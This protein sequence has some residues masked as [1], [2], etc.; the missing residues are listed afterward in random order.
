M[1]D[2]EKLKSLLRHIEN[3]RN[4]AEILGERLIEN[5]EDRLGIELIRNSQIHDLSKFSGIE[6][7]F[8]FHP[9]DKVNLAI[10]VKQHNLT[11]KHH[12]ESWG[13][14]KNMP[15]VY[16]AELACD[17]KARSSEFGSSLPDYIHGEAMKR[18]NFTKEDE[19]YKRLMR[20]VNMLCEKPFKPLV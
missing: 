8:L 1:K 12:P 9:E 7:E 20:F 16:L 14:I 5:G 2:L 10:A 15:D 17:W 4:N 13:G 6:W 19:I 11:N 18:F 3:V